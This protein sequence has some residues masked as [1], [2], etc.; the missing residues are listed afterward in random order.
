MRR[1]LN[2]VS[3]RTQELQAMGIPF[4]NY[5]EATVKNSFHCYCPYVMSI[6]S[7]ACVVEVVFAVPPGSLWF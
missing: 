2:R 4:R 3:P 1:C 5:M 6:T 7:S